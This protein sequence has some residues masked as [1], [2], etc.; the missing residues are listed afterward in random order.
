MGS[1]MCIRDSIFAQ[2]DISVYV[3]EKR[4]ALAHPLFRFL[5]SSLRAATRGYRVD[6]LMECVRTGYCN[7]TDEEAD[8]LDTYA[9]V[10]GIRAGRMRYPFTFGGE[11]E[12]SRAEEL[13]ARVV[14]PLLRLQRALSGAK[15]ASGTVDAIFYYLEERAAFDTL[16]REQQ[17]LMDAGLAVEAFDCAQVWNLLMELLDQMHTLLGGHR[18]QMR[19]VMDLSLIHI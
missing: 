14:E 19:T 1:E 10:Y 12:V 4:P 15:D 5:L 6:D 9:T 18:G 17:A 3:S 8:A 7:L 11:E 16:Q 13:R 2:Y